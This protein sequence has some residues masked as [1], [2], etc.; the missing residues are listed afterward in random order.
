[1]SAPVEIRNSTLGKL[2]SA[3]GPF[4]GVAIFAFF[5]LKGTAGG[6]PGGKV[7]LLAVLTRSTAAPLRLIMR[8][9]AGH[10]GLRGIS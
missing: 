7:F 8:E 6:A 4:I 9:C 1:M 5:M 10:W 3:L 2:F